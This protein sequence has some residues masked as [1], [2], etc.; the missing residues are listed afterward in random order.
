VI[1]SNQE[2][3]PFTSLSKLKVTSFFP[4]E[5]LRGIDVTLTSAQVQFGSARTAC[6]RF[7]YSTTL[8]TFNN[9]NCAA[10][11]TFRHVTFDASLTV[12]L[13]VTAAGKFAFSCGTT[14]SG[15]G[16]GCGCGC[17]A[18]GSGEEVVVVAFVLVVVV[19]VGGGG[20]AGSALVL[21][22][23]WTVVSPAHA[24]AESITRPR[25]VNFIVTLTDRF[26]ARLELM[27]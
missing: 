12:T 15:F 10:S 8:L 4:N 3:V 1:E 24:A 6:S 27:T 17:G 18:G 19:V 25:I 13:K 7:R 11:V 23:L 21:L 5:S 20:G 14:G 26:P 2:D 16:L 9:T 22:E